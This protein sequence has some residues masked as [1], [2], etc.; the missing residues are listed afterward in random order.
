MRKRKGKEEKIS[1]IWGGKE[2]M[3]DELVGLGG[4]VNLVQFSIACLPTSSTY[5]TKRELFNVFGVDMSCSSSLLDV[6][7][8]NAGRVGSRRILLGFPSAGV[9]GRPRVTGLLTAR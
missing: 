4:A 7:P 5:K 8:G 9:D 3:M 2:R 1:K 6:S